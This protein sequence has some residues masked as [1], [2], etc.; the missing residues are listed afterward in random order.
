MMRRTAWLFV[1]LLSTCRSGSDGDPWEHLYAEDGDEPTEGSATDDDVT[2]DDA[3]T[4]PAG[5]SVPGADDATDD[6]LSDEATDAED[7]DA[8][9]DALSDDDVT[10]DVAT[11]DT[12]SVPT[13]RD[14]EGDPVDVDITDPE[15]PSDVED[16]DMGETEC[17]VSTERC[18]GIDN[19]CDER[20]D[21][22]FVCP[23]EPGVV[24]AVPYEGGVYLEG[25]TISGSA[26]STALQ[27]FWPGVEE[28]YID[29]FDSYDDR[30]RIRRSDNQLFFTNRM[31]LHGAI[32]G[33][34]LLEPCLGAPSSWDFDA[35]GVISYS[36]GSGIFRAGQQLASSGGIFGV[37]DDGRVVGAGDL[38]WGHWQ[39]TEFT[40]ADLEFGSARIRGGTPT[41]YGNV[42]AFPLLVNDSEIAVVKFDEQSR[43]TLMRRQPVV[44]DELGSNFLAIPDGTIF[45]S[46]WDPNDREHQRIIAYLPDGSQAVA[47]HQADGGPI[48][49]LFSLFPGPLNSEDILH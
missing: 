15:D 46:Q 20:V 10:D 21:E 7:E 25:T 16:T 23:P 3:P 42:A 35:D 41:F 44:A 31:E 29:G 38:G 40:P 2:D 9:D 12:T 48:K 26:S 5:S 4:P 18:D 34:V 33:V 36:C 22:G 17:V 45:M 37:T 1:L 27:R 8:S 11:D 13:D 39:G 43:W 6:A 49:N 32:D 47:W 24:G 19:D 28:S 30:F 14:S